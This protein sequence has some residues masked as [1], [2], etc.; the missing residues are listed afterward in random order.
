VLAIAAARLGFTPVTAVDNEPAAI[1]TAI[2]NGRAN[3]VGLDHVERLDLREERPPVAATVTANL[4]RPLLLRVADLMAERP[5]R[6]IVSGLLEGEEHEVVE[7][8]GPLREYRRARSGG[9][10]ALL[11]TR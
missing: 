3:G 8:F 10:S 4:T 2:A 7:A 6:L 5:E 1:E 11:L 9:W